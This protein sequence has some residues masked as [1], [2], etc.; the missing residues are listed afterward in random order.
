MLSWR[1]NSWNFEFSPAITSKRSADTSMMC[2]WSSLSF[3]SI[4]LRELD[5]SEILPRG[6]PTIFQEIKGTL[7]GQYAKE[8]NLTIVVA[9][10]QRQNHILLFGLKSSKSIITNRCWTIQQTWNLE[11]VWFFP[12][13]ATTSYFARNHNWFLKLRLHSNGIVCSHITASSSLKF[14]FS[15]DLTYTYALKIEIHFMLYSTRVLSKA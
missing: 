8:M 13:L 1:Q 6:F 11:C 3:H 2:V 5:A 12:S 14:W 4:Y 9:I 10:V 15:T 7:I